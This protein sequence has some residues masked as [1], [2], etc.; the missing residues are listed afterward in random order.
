MMK[1][2]KSDKLD[3]KNEAGNDTEKFAKPTEN[4]LDDTP[5]GEANPVTDRSYD[6][7]VRDPFFAALVSDIER[8]NAKV[9]GVGD[10][11][12]IHRFRDADEYD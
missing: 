1:M 8:L 11:M 6:Y 7:Y 10:A 9:F 4:I 2:A 3:T 12:A 5:T